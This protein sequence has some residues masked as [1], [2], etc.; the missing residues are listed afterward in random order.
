MRL[1]DAKEK[2]ARQQ[3]VL[4]SS[5]AWQACLHAL[6]AFQGTQETVSIGD[7]APSMSSSSTIRPALP[8]PPFPPRLALVTKN[9]LQLKSD[10][11]SLTTH[12]QGWKRHIAATSSSVTPQSKLFK[13][14]PRSDLPVRTKK[15][16]NKQ[17]NSWAP[18]TSTNYFIPATMLSSHSPASSVRTS[19]KQTLPLAR[20]H[21]DTL[22]HTRTHTDGI[23]SLSLKE[24]RTLLP[25][26]QQ[27][28]WSH[29]V[30]QH[31]YFKHR[32]QT[33][34]PQTHAHRPHRPESNELHTFT[35]YS[36]AE[37]L[38]SHSPTP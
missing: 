5:C 25:I 37:R 2:A 29:R 32:N 28:Q 22:S 1:W 21:T 10:S 4:Y 7:S 11:K 8:P 31:P 6:P 20:A 18:H 15:K 17:E 26:I 30:L 24:L 38:S 16:G 19:H 33:L 23:I 34:S 13:A 12:L 3:Q 14:S 27:Q 35:N 9:Q 36:P